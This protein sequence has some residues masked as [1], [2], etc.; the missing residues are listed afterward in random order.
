MAKLSPVRRL[1]KLLHPEAIPSPGAAI[2]NLVSST[3]M[4]QHHYDLVASDIVSYCPSGHLL[5]LGTGP[6]WLLLKL[7]R[8]APELRL[9]GLDASSS[10]VARARKNVASAGLGRLIEI[11]E[12]NAARLPFPDRSFDIVVST[13]SI[14]HWKHPTA[15]LN[16]AYRVLKDGGFA[17]MYDLVTD[18]P[19]SLSHRARRQF[20]RVRTI[21]FWLH[22]FE[23]PF[24]SHRNFAALAQPTLF[25]EGSTR[26]VGLLCC[27][28]LKK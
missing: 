14:H 13:G 26:F 3:S 19:A 27:L 8:Q 28:V 23:E 18:L 7:H 11:R 4:F 6:A 5:D 21:I 9:T 25:G 15:A 24:Y 1:L 22:G 16:E 17:L 10:M 2:Y 12:G 20:G